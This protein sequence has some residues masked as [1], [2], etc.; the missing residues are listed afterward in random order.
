M[1]DDALRFN[2]ETG[3]EAHYWFTVSDFARLAVDHNDLPKM[4][5]DVEL[6][7]K[8]LKDKKHEHV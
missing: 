4:I 3:E 8:Q 6:L 1:D 2:T 7:I 5:A